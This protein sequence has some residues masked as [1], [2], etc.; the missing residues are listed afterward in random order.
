MPSPSLLSGE[1]RRA[2]LQKRSCS[3]I[4]I[5][6]RETQSE[7]HALQKQTLFERLLQP[8]V[9]RLERKPYRGPAVSQNLVRHIA[10]R[11]KQ[12]VE[13][14]YLIHQTPLQGKV[15]R[16]RLA[17][18]NHLQSSSLPDQAR[19]PLQIGRAAWGGR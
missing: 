5:R 19:G 11:G 14:D 17:L 8:L 15:G 10:R 4:H 6:S 18:Q 2:L 16:Y 7:Q 12:L 13:R 3:F 9:D 1:A